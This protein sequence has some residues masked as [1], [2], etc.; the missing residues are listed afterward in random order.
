MALWQAP[1]PVVESNIFEHLLIIL[2]LT[3]SFFCLQVLFLVM[4]PKA[5]KGF[6]LTSSYQVILIYLIALAWDGSQPCLSMRDWS[7]SL[8][9]FPILKHMMGDV[10]M[11]H[12]LL[13][14]RSTEATVAPS[15]SRPLKKA[16]SQLSKSNIITETILN[17]SNSLKKLALVNF[18]ILIVK[19]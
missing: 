17:C 7:S 14:I 6:K 19:I 15:L 1:A 2:W 4:V 9:L 3:P 10:Q 18:G 8:N 16:Y 12:T 13:G 5:A 11:Y